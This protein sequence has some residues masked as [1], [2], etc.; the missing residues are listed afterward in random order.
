MMSRLHRRLLD[1]IAGAFSWLRSCWRL[2]LPWRRGG[3]WWRSRF[4][5][6]LS[7]GR[8][9]G[10]F[11]GGGRQ[12]RFGSLQRLR[13]EALEDRTMLAATIAP[14]GIPQWVFQGPQPIINTGG[15]HGLTFGNATVAPNNPAV[16]AIESIAVNPHN[17]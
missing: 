2:P 13:L 11:L 14:T 9:H 3:S 7:P 4:I 15:D 17:S 16:G 1:R 5:E 6:P 10:W 8:L 12:E